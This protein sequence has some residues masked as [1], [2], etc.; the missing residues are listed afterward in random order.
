[1]NNLETQLFLV[2][3]KS[4]KIYYPNF[5]F[6]FSFTA[7]NGSKFDTVLLASAFF[8]NGIA[9]TLITKGS[10]EPQLKS[11][12]ILTSKSFKI[13]CSKIFFSVSV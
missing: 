11:H 8:E 10:K 9:P 2:K 4:Y 5:L 3:I 7:H 6:I 13:Y 12:F 1:M